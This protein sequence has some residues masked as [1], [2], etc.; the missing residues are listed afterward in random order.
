MNNIL[1]TTTLLNDFG[2]PLFM[3]ELSGEKDFRVTE[4]WKEVE[5][6]KEQSIA[7]YQKADSTGKYE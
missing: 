4:I 2:I 6:L 1:S 7:K 3:T 5:S